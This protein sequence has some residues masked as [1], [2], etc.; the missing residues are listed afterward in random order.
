MSNPDIV[1]VVVTEYIPP[2]HLLSPASILPAGLAARDSCGDGTNEF[3]HISPLVTWKNLPALYFIDS[4]VPVGLVQA[5]VNCFNV[6]NDTAGFE[7]Y[8]RT[9]TESTSKIQVS[10][11]PI[12][13]AGGTLAR[14][15]W[16]YS[17]SRNEMTRATIVFD[18]RERWALLANE[19]CGSNGDIF[20]IMNVGVHEVGHISGLSHAPTDRLQT[21]YASTGPGMT[22][23]RSL[24]NGD[25]EGFKQAY[26]GAPLPCPPGQHLENGV[27][28]PDTPPPCQ[29]IV[30]PPNMHFDMQLCK[31]VED[32]P[33]PPPPPSVTRPKIIMQSGTAY[34]NVAYENVSGKFINVKNLPFGG[35]HAKIIAESGKQYVYLYYYRAA[36]LFTTLGRIPLQ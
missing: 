7:L 21:M 22:L 28:V 12:D 2:K 15:S 3:R 34:L 25:I 6:W 5:V 13:A 20:D 24:G 27:C 10:V 18:S 31:C 8:R 36:N 23:G 9:S 33:P 29:P 32:I 35:P 17:T 11:S 16:S 4:T 30:C 26:N 14:A 19:S 1:T